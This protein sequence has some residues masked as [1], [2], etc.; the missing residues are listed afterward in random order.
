MKGL[1]KNIQNEDNECFRRCLVRHLNHVNKNPAKIRNFNIE[2]G[3]QLNCMGA[4]CPVHIKRLCK[5]R[6]NNISINIFGYED[7]T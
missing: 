7:E 4:K 2:F 5:N 6:K 3:K 1:I